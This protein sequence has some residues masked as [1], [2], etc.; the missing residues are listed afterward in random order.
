MVARKRPA[1]RLRR[2]SG[3][4]GNLELR[5][6]LLHHRYVLRDSLTQVIRR[7]LSSVL[8][9]L[10]IG[11]AL[12]LPALMYVTDKNLRALAGQW[13]D[14]AQL[15]LYLTESTDDEAGRAL[16]DSLR[17]RDEISSARFL[18]ST[19]ALDEFSERLS[20]DSALA[21]LDR[22]PLPD[23]IIIVPESQT[24]TDM[25]ALG[26]VLSKLPEVTSLQYDIEWV[27][28]LEQL[29]RFLDRVLLASIAVLA[30]TVILVVGNTMR[31]A[32]EARRDEIQVV[33]LVGA[34]AGFVRRPF[35]YMGFWYGVFG[36]LAAIV[37]TLVTLWWLRAPVLDLVSSYGAAATLP[38]L[39]VTEGLLLIA[40]AV[41]L[42]VGSTW[43][44]VTRRINAIEPNPV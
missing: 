9:W 10:V 30:L 32:T 14:G 19:E 29:A 4:A 43:L 5:A 17:Q 7:P 37:I 22:N 41:A 25:E 11:I 31:M 23:S 20:L 44:T 35:L 1:N 21:G 24:R 13:Q 6:W 38:G 28:R 3:A 36:G 33:K 26:A 15:T 2:R 39:T 40:L 34:T 27:Q 8:T 42:S 16:T 18:S 12:A